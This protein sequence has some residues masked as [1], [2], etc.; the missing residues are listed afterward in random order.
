MRRAR[1]DF[2]V[3]LWDPRID[4]SINGYAQLAF[5]DEKYTLS[6]PPKTTAMSLVP[7]AEAKKLLEGAT[8]YQARWQR[9]PHRLARDD[10]GVYYFVDCAREDS[11]GGCSRD[12]RLY[13][14]QRGKLALQQMTNIVS[15]SMG[16]IF[17]TKSGELRL[18]LNEEGKGEDKSKALK[19]V[20]GKA[21]T[22]LVNVP[23]ED[24]ARL[25]YTGLASTTG[26]SSVRPAT[27]CRRVGRSGPFGGSHRGLSATATQ[28]PGN[29]G[30]RA[31][32]IVQCGRC[33]SQPPRRACGRSSRPS[34]AATRC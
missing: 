3:S 8:L 22:P 13:T 5:R 21:V 23:V 32:N 6:C 7:D 4:W 11:L 27:T 28:M 9:L 31:A 16:Q 20:N 24:N 15:D 33:T 30:V 29:G 18:V 1:S 14:G 19:W 12:W 17:S 34:S 26:R 10:S 2:S 25:I